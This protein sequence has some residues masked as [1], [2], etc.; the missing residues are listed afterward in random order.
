ME[1]FNAL[2]E[3]AKR[4][5][6]PIQRELAITLV[7]PLDND[8]YDFI[9]NQAKYMLFI[10]D[11]NGNPTNEELADRMH[12]AI[13][14]ISLLLEGAADAYQDYL[15]RGNIAIVEGINKALSGMNNEKVG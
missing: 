8:L 5:F 14:G 1:K 6:T 11:G 9:Y 4:D 10:V 7:L 15:E 12:K 2:R 3:L 13:I